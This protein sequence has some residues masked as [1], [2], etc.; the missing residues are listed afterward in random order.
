MTKKKP[1][2]KAR[3]TMK[4]K[5]IDLNIPVPIELLGSKD[6][7][8]FAKLHDPRAQEC[9]R[10]GDSEICAIAMGQANH[11][12]RLAEHKKKSFKDLEERD[13]KP[14]D[15][16]V[17]GKSVRKRIREMLRMG[18][19]NWVEIPEVVNDIFA[20]YGKDGYTKKRIERILIMMEKKSNY[21]ILTK[22]KAKW[23]RSQK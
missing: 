6:D 20:S 23:K 3:D 15:K 17:L 8:C 19:G 12:L 5:Q 13:I 10:C 22:S 18:G 14:A 2:R 7:P 1:K 21:I 16:K 4:E 11:M 9:K